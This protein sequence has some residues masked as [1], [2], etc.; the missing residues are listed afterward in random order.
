[1][2]GNLS[3]FHKEFSSPEVFW[4]NQGTQQTIMK[5]PIQ[6]RELELQSKDRGFSGCRGDAKMEFSHICLFLEAIKPL[7]TSPRA[8]GMC[9]FANNINEG[10][11][12]YPDPS[13][14]H[15]CLD[16]SLCQSIVWKFQSALSCLA[17]NLH[18]IP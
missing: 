10:V 5:S 9:Y 12:F 14:F 4:Q 6:C 2:V 17:C 13:P 3:F 8:P 18:R 11:L 15:K 7:G 1:L 16:V